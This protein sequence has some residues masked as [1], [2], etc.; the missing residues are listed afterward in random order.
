M[1][2][3]SNYSIIAVLQITNLRF[4]N[5]KSSGDGWFLGQITVESEESHFPKT[6]FIASEWISGAESHFN[7]MDTG[8][9]VPTTKKLDTRSVFG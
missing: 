6:T 8:L 4:V 7:N 3:L 2:F 9:L 5:R 1:A